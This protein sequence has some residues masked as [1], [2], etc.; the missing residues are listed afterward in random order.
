MTRLLIVDDDAVQARALARAFSRLRPDFTLLTANSGLE[1]TQ[2]M[3]GQAVD[4]VLTDLQMPEMDGFELV[5]WILNNCPDV[6]VFT[7][8]AFG[9]EQ[10]AARL[11]RM[12]GIEYLTKPL[13]AKQ[14]LA[15]L[16]EALS[17]S[18]RGHVQNVSLA[19][20]LQLMEMERKTCNLTIRSGDKVGVL[21][22]RKG[23]LIDAHCGEVRGEDAAISIIA[24]P[25]SSI[26]ISRH[27]EFG[28]PVIEKSLGFIVMEAMRVQDEAARNAPPP[29]DGSGSIFPGPRVSWRPNG[30]SADSALPPANGS[31][32]PAIRELGLPS[33]T[34]AIAVVET[35]T[36]AVLQF[37]AKDGCPV[38][39]LAR[40][41]ALVVRHQLNTLTLCSENEGIEELVLSTSTYCDVIRPIGNGLAQFALLVFAPD[42]TNLVMARIEL[43][44]FIAGR[45]SL[46]PLAQPLT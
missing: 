30:A 3:S 18:V 9:T 10:T 26:M 5:A 24:W 45:S 11:E 4:L 28:P 38:A 44:R 41:A 29:L 40:S 42:E 13:D 34:S 33:G 27:G 35:A 22:I 43:D 39:E 14:T 25:N 12:G 17:Q 20:F 36:G 16:T 8:S 15:R 1:A 6:A 31:Y 32:L 2:L 19:S 37:A 21:V 23:Q 46:A 7:M